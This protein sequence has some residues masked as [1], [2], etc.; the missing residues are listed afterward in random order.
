[1]N[2]VERPSLNA[3]DNK[4]I[5]FNVGIMKNDD[6]RLCILQNACTALVL[7]SLRIDVFFSKCLGIVIIV[8]VNYG[9]T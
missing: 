1:M 8:V 6:F 5:R 4:L 2:S 9:R 7:G 3:H